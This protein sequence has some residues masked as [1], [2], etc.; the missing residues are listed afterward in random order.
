MQLSNSDMDDLFRDAAEKYPLKTDNADWEKVAAKLDET[1]KQ[2]TAGFPLGRTVVALLLL[3]FLSGS[4]WYF[5]H[6]LNSENATEKKSLTA[7]TSQTSVQQNTSVQNN[8]S[9][10]FTKHPSILTANERTVNNL[11]SVPVIMSASGGTSVPAD[12]SLKPATDRIDAA[13]TNKT[14]EVNTQLSQ[15]QQSNVTAPPIELPMH[16]HYVKNFNT[17]VAANEKQALT[18]AD[19]NTSTIIKTTPQKGKKFYLTA[20]VGIDKSHVSLQKFAKT[21]S[22]YGITAG[23]NINSHFS[24]EAGVFSSSKNYYTGAQYFNTAKFNSPSYVKWDWFNGECRMLE[25]PVLIRYNF[26]PAKKA[27]WFAAAG[28]SSYLMNK[29]VYN[30]QY[31]SYGQIKFGSKTYDHSSKDWLGAMQLSAGVEKTLTKNSSIRI[32]PYMRMPIKKMGYG[33]LPISSV[34]LNIGFRKNLF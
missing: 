20:M 18:N 26:T 3:A 9:V 6:S 19:N 27:Q 25:I 13:N 29:E 11:R 21:G 12:L 34:G 14:F 31:H 4:A 15:V 17:A 32:E 5:T 30:Y 33:D 10:A 23:Y 2:T 1:P 7:R 8:N 22:S 28:V 16:S 24:I